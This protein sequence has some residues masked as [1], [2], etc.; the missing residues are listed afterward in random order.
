MFSPKFICQS[1]HPKDDSIKIQALE[2]SLV[3]Q[4]VEDPVFSLLCLGFG[5]GL[6]NFHT[7]WVQPKKK[8]K[9]KNIGFLG[10]KVR[11]NEV[12][13]VRPNSI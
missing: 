3:V 8:K 6:G 10:G 7:L 11:L 4:W 1:P 13:R 2:N 9:K 12:I 5:H